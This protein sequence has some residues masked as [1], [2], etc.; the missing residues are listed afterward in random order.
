MSSFFSTF[1]LFVY[2]FISVCPLCVLL[3]S[4]SYTILT[5]IFN[6]DVFEHTVSLAVEFPIP[7]SELF[8]L[9]EVIKH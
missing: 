6:I 9:Q 4:M 3:Y 7:G 8:R 5:A 2:F 1:Y